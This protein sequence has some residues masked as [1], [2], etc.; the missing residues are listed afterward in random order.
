[1][2]GRAGSLALIASCQVAGLALWFSASAAV[3]G[4]I[5]SGRL[6]ARAASLLTTAVQLGFVAGTL[7]SAILGLADRYDPRR[8]FAACA[9]AGALANAAILLTEI[10]DRPSLFLRFLTGM[11]LAGVYP[12][13]M[14]LAAGWAE[15]N[16]GLLIGGLVGALTLGSAL[17]HLFN[18]L[19]G[20]AWQSAIAGASLSALLAAAGIMLA[21]L[22]P[23]HQTASAF[24]P[25]EA[26]L[27]LRQRPI[28]LANAGYLGHM[29]EL[30]AMWAWIG[31]F[32]AFALGR[33][34]DP[35]AATS[36][37]AA[38]TFLVMASG[39]IGAVLAGL[40]ADRVGRTLVT[41]WA[42]AISGS[43]ALII[44]PVAE[45]GVAALLL[46]AILW[47]ITVIADSAQFSAA[48]A[49]LAPARLTGSMLTLQTCLGFLLTVATIQL[50][51]LAIELLTWRYAFSVL[52]IG[53]FLG[54]LAMWRLRLRPEAV[55]IAGGRR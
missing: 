19:G 1:M 39:A 22:G 5:E 26:F 49:E 50:M 14:K 28:L 36:L 2:T 13:G 23:R 17:P 34:G 18:F 20:L 7:L 25:D 38:S 35:A 30:Y 48:I 3:P 52:A 10:G 8:F 33:E 9:V 12:V 45:L 47:G 41:I 53:P 32:L 15:R 54:A 11:A 40:L 51:P 21:S 29:W 42:M 55:R 24:R 4:L 43:C 44:G 31:A 27:L 46:V 6:E 16:M 37:A